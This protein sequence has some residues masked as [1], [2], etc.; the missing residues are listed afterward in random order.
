MPNARVP[1]S[2]SYLA[3][4]VRFYPMDLHWDGAKSGGAAPV[5]CRPGASL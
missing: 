2:S 3:K 1:A 4:L 5:R